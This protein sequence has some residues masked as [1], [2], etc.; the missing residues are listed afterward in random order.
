MTIAAQHIRAGL[1]HL[2]AADPVMKV[3]IKSVGPFTLKPRSDR[4]LTLVQ[5]VVSQQIST[6]A[7]DSIFAGL[8]NLLAPA[9]LTPESLDKQSLETL[10]SAG[11]SRQKAT[12]LL[13]LSQRCL[14]GEVTLSKT[15]RWS[16]TEVIQHL[17][18]V[19]GIGPWS[20]KMFLIF[21]LGRL[22]ILAEEDLGIRNAIKLHYQ[23]DEVPNHST[24]LAVA[25]P[26]A[27]YRTM[28]SWYLWQSL[29]LPK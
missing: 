5:G 7:A 20:A 23:L 28:A 26:W 6:K 9:S 27:P 12:Y 15:G 22:D 11:I 8:L 4:F 19:K 21:S 29:N 14:A 3:I 16:E 10:R 18:Q 1:K 17:T 24:V 13:D 25:Q 2:R